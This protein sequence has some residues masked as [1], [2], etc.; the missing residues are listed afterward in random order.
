MSR[1]RASAPNERLL[2]C[3]AAHLSEQ[4][5]Q[6]RY[7]PIARD[8]QPEQLTVHLAQVL[9]Q[10]LLRDSHACT[11]EDHRFAAGV[12]RRFVFA[13]GLQTTA[14]NEPVDREGLR[15]LAPAGLP[16][17][18][19]TVATVLA[20]LASLPLI[21]TTE[22]LDLVLGVD[23]TPGRGYRTAVARADRGWG[24][25]ERAGTRRPAALHRRSVADRRFGCCRTDD[26]G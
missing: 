6:R 10:A 17:V 22:Q 24:R 11:P 4:V 8:Y 25:P 15:A 26:P 23:R 16:L 13:S 9:E 5:V 19:G 18:D 3:A 20:E 21:S 12:H 7:E 1:L 14:P 2:R